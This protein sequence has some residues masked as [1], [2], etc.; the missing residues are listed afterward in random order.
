MQN[1]TNGFSMLFLYAL[2]DIKDFFH[3]VVNNKMHKVLLTSF[4]SL[5][6]RN[7]DFKCHIAATQAQAAL[8]TFEAF[9][10][11]LRMTKILSGLCYIMNRRHLV[12]IVAFSNDIQCR[13]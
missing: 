2:T 5:P 3:V 8:R 9:S 11:K 10:N 13:L 12:L 4:S 1:L 7:N 6:L